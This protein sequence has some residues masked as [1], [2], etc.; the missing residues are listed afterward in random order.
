MSCVLCFLFHVVPRLTGA[1][2]WW[3]R[4]IHALQSQYCNKEEKKWNGGQA[5]SAYDWLYL[6]YW[7]TETQGMP[8]ADVVNDI[9]LRKWNILLNSR[10]LFSP[11][12]LCFPCMY[13]LIF[14]KER[15]FHARNQF[16]VSSY[17][18]SDFSILPISPVILCFSGLAFT[19]GKN[20]TGIWRCIIAWCSRKK[21]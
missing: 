17:K 14:Y 10:I 12:R 15:P 13:G 20:T 18:Y 9:L 8:T 3:S 1:T 16:S 5:D 21:S 4:V 11:G 6:W 19:I 7:R 2:S